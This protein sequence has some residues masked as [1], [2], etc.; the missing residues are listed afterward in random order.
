MT[1][2]SVM[3]RESDHQVSSRLCGTTRMAL[4]IIIIFLTP[5]LNSRGM[6]KLRYYYYYLFI[7]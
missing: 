7:F 4:I 3:G 6:K 5:V 1:Y 2:R